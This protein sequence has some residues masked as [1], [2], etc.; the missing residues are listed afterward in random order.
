MTSMRHNSLPAIEISWSSK[1]LIPSL[2]PE[3]IEAYDDPFL[4]GRGRDD[5]RFGGQRE[6]W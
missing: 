2:L 6:A 1:S 3:R 5:L 4:V